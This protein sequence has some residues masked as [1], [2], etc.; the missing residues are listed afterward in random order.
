[1][2]PIELRVM[3]HFT[4]RGPAHAALEVLRDDPRSEELEIVVR[5]P[6]KPHQTVPI[7][8]SHARGALAKGVLV[9]GLTGLAMGALIGWLGYTFESLRPGI[10]LAFAAIGLALGLLG[11]ALIGPTNPHPVLS[12]LEQ[13]GV[14]I[15][16]DARD[17]NLRAWAERVL[18]D[19]GADILHTDALSRLRTSTAS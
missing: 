8:L 17:P 2:S 15:V 12:K 3:G 4:D 7:P 1:M 9:G 6:D 16:V 13:Q 10:M 11:A 5:V 19:H 18:R 14:T